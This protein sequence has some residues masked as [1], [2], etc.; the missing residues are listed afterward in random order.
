MKKPRRRA[1]PGV[2]TRPARSPRAPS[3]CS[4][5]GDYQRRAIA[6]P[7]SETHPPGCAR[8][9]RAARSQQRPLV[10][11]PRLHRTTLGIPSSA[12]RATHR[13]SAPHRAHGHVPRFAGFWPPSM[14]LMTEIMQIWGNELEAAYFDKKTLKETCD[15]LVEKTNNLLKGEEG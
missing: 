10:L 14:P 2:L 3:V 11:Q 15:T 13:R 1:L 8:L 4:P 9:S 6:R 5:A 7:V 12:A